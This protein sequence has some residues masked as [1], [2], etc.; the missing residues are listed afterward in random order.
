MQNKSKSRE[1]SIGTK[2]YTESN[3]Y[4]GGISGSPESLGPSSTQIRDPSGI[5]QVPSNMGERE[6]GSGTLSWKLGYFGG[7]LCVVLTEIRGFQRTPLNQRL[8]VIE[9]H[10]LYNICRQN[11]RNTTE[12]WNIVE[13]R[14]LPRNTVPG[15]PSPPG[16]F[17]FFP[18]FQLDIAK[19]L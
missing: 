5:F 2:L 19:E 6:R 18:R 16:K 15:L 13:I 14:H 11:F 3:S 12:T 4:F 17:F 10:A 8:Q 1:F 9:K 7:A